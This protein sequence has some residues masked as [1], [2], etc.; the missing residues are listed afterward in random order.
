[1]QFPLLVRCESEHVLHAWSFAHTRARSQ[2]RVSSGVHVGALSFEF[3]VMMVNLRD[4]L[5]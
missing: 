4:L 5:W 2:G 1:M 3:I